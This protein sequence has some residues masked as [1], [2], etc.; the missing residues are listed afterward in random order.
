MFGLFKRNDD[1]C[2]HDWQKH[3]MY[4]QHILTEYLNGSD[5][6]R[7]Y[8]V[9]KCTKCLNEKIEKVS[10]EYYP[11]NNKDSF[12]LKRNYLE[13]LKSKNVKSKEEYILQ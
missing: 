5:C 6:I 12:T 10:E 1:W 3:G 7:L 8:E 4:F 2:Y 13:L 9:E 11:V